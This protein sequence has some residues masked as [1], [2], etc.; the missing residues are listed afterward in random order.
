MMAIV[1]LLALVMHGNKKAC[2]WYIL[3]SCLLMFCI[4]GLRD[5]YTIGN[6]STTS[7]LHLYERLGKTSWGDIYSSSKDG[8]NIGFSYLMKIVYSISGGNYQTFIVLTSAIIMICFAHFVKRYSV[9]PVQSF[10]YYWGLLLYAFTFSA[11][12]QGIAMAVLL[13]AFDAIIDKKVLKFILL[14]ILASLFHFPA[15]V[16]MPAYWIAKIR[17]GRSYYLTLAAILILTYIF[18]DQLL[19]LM[20]D[21]YGNEEESYSMEGIRFLGNKVIIMLIIV[22][23]ALLLRTPTRDDRIYNILLEFM[24][25]AIVFQ[26]F[27]GYNNI[28]ERLADYYFQYATVFI[29]MVFDKAENRNRYFSESTNFIIKT[30]APYL[31]CAFGVWRY[32]DYIQAASDVFLPYVFYF[33]K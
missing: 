29:P 33:Q 27:C 28:F 26:T 21:V 32:A 6:D 2:T 7:Y 30:A 9:S 12:K 14:V 15:L 1:L 18:R 10:C 25:I 13:L 4:L 31:F 16:F 11:E 24:G 22:V 3:I 5:A 17:I 8:Y 20:M 19:Q 23:A